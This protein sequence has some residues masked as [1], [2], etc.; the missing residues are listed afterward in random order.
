MEG[1]AVED[2]A[3]VAMG[4]DTR[5]EAVHLDEIGGIGKSEEGRVAVA[6]G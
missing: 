5:W 4:C 6:H 2:P 1:T 3:A